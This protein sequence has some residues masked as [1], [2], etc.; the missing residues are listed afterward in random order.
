MVAS[1]AMRVRGMETV[2]LPAMAEP[3]V[4][5]AMDITEMPVPLWLRT[6]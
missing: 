6:E 3:Q 1:A 5:A 4:T 2:V